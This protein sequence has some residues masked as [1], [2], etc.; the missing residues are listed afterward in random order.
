MFRKSAQYY[1]D[2]YSFKNYREEVDRIAALI[3][4]EHPAA[5]TILDVACGTGEH[6]KLLSRDFS[7][8][9]IDLEPEFVKISRAKVAAGSF[10]VADMRSFNLERRYDVVQCLFSSI[11]Y[12]THPQDVV[13]ALRTFRRHLAP[14]GLMVVEPWLTPEK[15]KVGVP[16][17]VTVDKPGLKLCRMNVSGRAGVLS[18]L[19]FHYLVAGSGGVEHF[20]ETHELALYTVSE[21]LAF[22]AAANVVVKYDEVG[23]F[24]RGLY[25]ARLPDEP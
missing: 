25:V 23:I 18:I 15:W 24:G 2:I 16:S 12:L 20:E 9:G 11:G 7:V 13:E 14:G 4:A 3:R 1:D 10:R 8:D 17:M 22:F 19:D 21:M 5:K 6:A